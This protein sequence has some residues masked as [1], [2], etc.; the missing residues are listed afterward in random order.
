MEE[1]LHGDRAAMGIPAPREL[2]DAWR[3]Q[4][5]VAAHLIFIDE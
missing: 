4:P 1:G 5:A 3:N 2:A